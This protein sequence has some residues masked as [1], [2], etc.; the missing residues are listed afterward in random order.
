LRFS[1]GQRP[2]AGVWGACPGQPT[3]AVVDPSLS[4]TIAG[5]VGGARWPTL[6]ALMRN[7]STM[8]PHSFVSALARHGLQPRCLVFKDATRVIVSELRQTAA[9]ALAHVCTCSPRPHRAIPLCAAPRRKGRD[10]AA[11]SDLDWPCT[12]DLRRVSEEESFKSSLA[13]SD[14][15]HQRRELTR[16]AHHR[17][18]RLLLK[19]TL[20]S[21]STRGPAGKW[22]DR[23]VRA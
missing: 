15:T 12:E 11:C 3:T 19:G 18:E 2:G 17:P 9:C 16:G 7:G 23:G 22:H 13:H 8:P 14:H 10:E 21:T 5:P 1:L 6:L 4:R 20:A